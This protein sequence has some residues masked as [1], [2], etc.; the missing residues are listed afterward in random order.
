[1]QHLL[2]LNRD[3]LAPHLTVRLTRHFKPLAQQCSRYA[4]SQNPLDLTD[5][6]EALDQG[7]AEH[8]VPRD[9]N[10]LISSESLCGDIPG[11]GAVRD[12]RAAP[13]LIT[14]LTGYLQERFP[15]AEV[16]V[17][18]TTRDPQEWLFSVY[19]HVLRR[20][21]LTLT[22]DAF[23]K[24]YAKAADLDSVV[25]EIAAAIDPLETLYLPLNL[26]LTNSLGPGGALLDQ[27]PL[28]D[29]T[30]AALQPVGIGAAGAAPQVWG[31]FLAM[32]RSDVSD[33]ICTA[34]KEQ[35]AETA[36]LGHWQKA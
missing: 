23:A 14:Y 21:R 35:M 6:I 31:Q 9:R 25:A 19:R 26:A 36:K 3:L 2:W 13:A 8:P 32:N 15:E 16:R 11:H 4:V 34:E 7:F 29:E 30:R 27:V 28:P 22:P 17:I 33:T 20:S 24:D 5:L 1:M 18:L 10:L 12:Y